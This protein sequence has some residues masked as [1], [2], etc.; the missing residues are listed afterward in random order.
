[1]DSQTWKPI[2]G[3]QHGIF[4]FYRFY[5]SVEGK[6]G[7]PKQIYFEPKHGD[8]MWSA[9]LYEKAKLKEG[10]LWSFAAVTDEPPPE[11]A[12]AGHD[13]CPV[14]LQEKNFKTWLS[15]STSAKDELI[16]ILESVEPTYF[17]HY[18]AA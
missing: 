6:N 9:T 17:E 18:D 13:R 2:F 12:A 1:M 14:Y 15:P 16:S 8:L 7:K 4:P 5:E 11:V 3:K 10:E